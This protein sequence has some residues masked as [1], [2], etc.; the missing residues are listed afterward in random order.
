METPCAPTKPPALLSSDA[1]LSVAC[2][3][4]ES[5]PPW[6][7]TAPA[8]TSSAPFVAIV[9]PVLDRLPVVTD[10]VPVPESAMVP[11]SLISVAGARVRSALFVRMAPP[12]LSSVPDTPIVIGPVPDCVML[13]LRLIRLAAARASW[14]PVRVP[15]L[16]SSVAAET[17]VRWPDAIVPPALV[18]VCAVLTPRFCT[19]LM[20]LALLSWPACT[21]TLPLP[22]IVPP[23]A[24]LSRPVVVRFRPSVLSEAMW[25][26]VLSRLPAL[27]LSAPAA[28]RVPP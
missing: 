14:L 9:P 1:T 20:V 18:R 21:V 15:A 13:P 4:A 10:S 8:W 11:W 28:C 24:L 3:C 27:A 12:V 23:W 7:D 17:F 5:L 6:F 16:L 26:A 19:A 22:P 25:P 2:D